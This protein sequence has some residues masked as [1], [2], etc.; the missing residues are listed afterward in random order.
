MDET[1]LDNLILSLATEDWQKTVDVIEQ[2]L[3]GC[4]AEGMDPGARAIG[5]RINALV[6]DGQLEAQGDV[7]D[8]RNAL[9]RI[10]RAKGQ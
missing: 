8:W 7:F 4:I 9:V 6:E 10:A 5:N 2:T 1:D 3:R